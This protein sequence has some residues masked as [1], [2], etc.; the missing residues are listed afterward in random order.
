[1]SWIS[2]LITGASNLIGG[3][4]GYQSQR[5]TNKA[6]M[7]LAKYQNEWNLEQWHRQNA[8][9]SPEQTVKR[10][11]DAGLSPR[12]L[13]NTSS[14][15][16]AAQSPQASSYNYSSPLSS[17]STMFMNMP[18]MLTLIQDLSVK[19]AEQ[20][21]LEA[22]ANKDNT[23]AALNSE[24]KLNKEYERGYKW[25]HEQLFNKYNDLTYS[26]DQATGKHSL[27]FG[28]AWRKS[29]YGYNVQGSAVQNEMS[30]MYSTIMQGELRKLQRE[31]EKDKQNFRN[32][33]GFNSPKEALPFLIKLVDLIFN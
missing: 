20:K 9:N 2:G 10:M 14:Y 27:K 33:T 21:K 26:Y 11:V 6:N 3:V 29:Y 17:L 1:M 30:G 7:N 8:Y 25:K 13:S 15:A 4:L 5:E 31:Y 18:N 24:V 22:Q 28:P 32:I 23:E 12:N 19:K 16:N